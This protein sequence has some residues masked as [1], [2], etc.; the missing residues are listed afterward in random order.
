MKDYFDIVTA[1]LL[2]LF[3]NVKKANK[4]IEDNY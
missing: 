3:K 1:C 2:E 4:S